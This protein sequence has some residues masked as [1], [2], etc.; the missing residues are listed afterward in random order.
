MLGSCCCAMWTAFRQGAT[1]SCHLRIWGAKAWPHFW[2]CLGLSHSNQSS[3]RPVTELGNHACRWHPL[4]GMQLLGGVEDL[5]PAWRMFQSLRILLIPVTGILIL[6]TI[7]CLL[8]YILCWHCYELD[9]QV[10]DTILAVVTVNVVV[11]LLWLVLL[12]Q[13]HHHW[14][15]YSSSG[16]IGHLSVAVVQA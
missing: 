9:H 1:L 16:L 3:Q 15:R 14:W 7:L 10:C 5:A 8:S 12:V 13:L 6:E 4:P 11:N 2:A